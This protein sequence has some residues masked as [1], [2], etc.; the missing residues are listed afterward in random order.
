MGALEA[1][2]C[3]L[4]VE[5]HRSRPN[6]SPSFERCTTASASGL[7]AA[8]QSETPSWRC[9][10]SPSMS[11]LTAVYSMS[12]TALQSSSTTDGFACS[13]SG[14]ILSATRCALAKNSRPSVRRISRPGQVSSSGC[15]FESAR[16]TC[17]PRLRPSA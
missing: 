15:S 2:D 12:V 17:V 4:H 14:R 6:V 8:S 3:R 16:K 13:M 1:V 11:I 7:S 10:S 5:E 9:F